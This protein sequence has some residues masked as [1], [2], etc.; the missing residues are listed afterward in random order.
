LRGAH[1]SL[2][3][4]FHPER[5]EGPFSALDQRSLAALGMTALLPQVV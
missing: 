5:S 4:N 1:M 2:R 3:Q